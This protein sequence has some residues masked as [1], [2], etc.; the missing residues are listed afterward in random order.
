MYLASNG[1]ARGG[2]W[3]IEALLEAKAMLITPDIV[4]DSNISLQCCGD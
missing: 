1:A 4:C 3:G 2:V